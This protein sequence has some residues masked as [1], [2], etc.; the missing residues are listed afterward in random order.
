MTT[1]K[2][3]A[4]TALDAPLAPYTLSRREPGPKDVE[5]EVLYC[6]ICHSDLHQARNEWGASTYPM[7]PG[8]EIA[9]RVTRVGKAVR[10]FKPGDYAGVGCLVDSCRKCAQCR[11]GREQFC[12]N[13][14][15][16]TYNGLEQDKK[17]PTQGGYSRL[18]V[19]SEAFAL[20]LAPGQPMERVAPLL[21]AGIT[22]YSPLRRF[23]VKRGS[24]VG[25]LG[26]GGLGHMA[27]KLAA[28]MGAEVTVVSRSNAK[29]PDAK[30]LGA[31]EYA[32]W[33]DPK[34]AGRFDL[35]I[36]TVSADHDVNAPLAWT[37]V[38]GAAVL[39]GAPPKP[40]A[41]RAFSVIPNKTLAGS[42]IGGI[43]ETQEM[44]DF[45]AKKKVWADVEVIAMKDV[46]AA[47]E[48]LE[49]GDVRYRFSI[50]CSTL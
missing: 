16:F 14:S 46:N 19:V 10:R 9:G 8:H 32:L 29:K 2:A 28:A 17:T 25:V 20:K 44:L 13:G 43:P 7:V 47:Y 27:V 23:G 11:K 50:D 35:V 12:E 39:V 34:L 18:L 45:C 22:T 31:H 41:L 49:R 30:R 24:R 1:T 33:D 37:K 4:A 21:C 5:L 38:G 36:D 6:G 26:L 40:L 48:R 15:S 3:Y 42:L